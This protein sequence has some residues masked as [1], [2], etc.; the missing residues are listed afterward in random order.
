MILMGV[1]EI[2]MPENFITMFKA[3]EN[4]EVIISHGVETALLLAAEIK[5]G[6]YFLETKPTFIGRFNSGIVNRLFIQC[7]L[8]LKDFML[9]ILVLVV[10]NVS[11]LV[12]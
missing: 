1:G 10:V 8:G 9:K 12:H 4:P 5:A 2:V 11:M 7:L 3:P 6:K